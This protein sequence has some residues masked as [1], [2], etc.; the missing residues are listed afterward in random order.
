MI[1]ELYII[2]PAEYKEHPCHLP[3]YQTISQ[4]FIMNL[5]KKFCIIGTPVGH[6][7]SPELY[8]RIFDEHG[9]PNYTYTINE[10]ES[11]QELAL[12]LEDMRGGAWDGCNV[13][14]PWKTLVA[15]EMD[16]LLDNAALTNAVNTVVRRCGV[17]YGDSTDGGGMCDAILSDT[18]VG[19]AGRKVIVLGCGGAARSI[20]AELA[21][22][23]A[24]KISI[25]CR[26]GKNKDLTVGL[27]ERI[28][29]KMAGKKKLDR[30]F[31]P[32]TTKLCDY[33]DT[34]LLLR[35]ISEADILINC[36]PVGMAPHENELPIP[37]S[38]TFPEDL[39]VAESIYNPDETRLIKK[40]RSCNCRTVKGIRML[41]LQAQRA[42]LLYLK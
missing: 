13:T 41:E 12:F 19:I 5:E 11:E 18:G 40:A 9:F 22:R 35:S 8:R 16:A 20:I 28:D 4:R 31:R 39:I 34:I 33:D 23:N 26:P 32:V 30:S 3:G 10:I 14:M 42:A 2:H 36:T 1:G 24:A 37:D 6:S 29:E 21:L 17:L 15:E 25:F 7:K 38:I 27:L